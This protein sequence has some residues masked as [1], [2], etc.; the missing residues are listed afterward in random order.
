MYCVNSFLNYIV[1]CIIL[2]LS[3]CGVNSYYL[4]YYFVNVY[5]SICTFF[6]EY[7][8][9][10]NMTEET[11]LAQ[12][13]VRRMK[14]YT[15]RTLAMLLALIMLIGLLPTAALAVDDVPEQAE[16]NAEAI[17]KTDAVEKEKAEANGSLKIKVKIPVG[18]DAPRIEQL[19]R[20]GNYSIT[21]HISAVPEEGD[22]S[23][24]KLIK[25]TVNSFSD[26]DGDGVW[27]GENT[28][29]NLPPMNYRVS[30]SDKEDHSE[31]PGYTSDV[32]FTPADSDPDYGFIEVKSGEPAAE[33]TVEKIYQPAYGKLVITK[34][35]TVPAGFTLSSFIQQ[36]DQFQLKLFYES[37]K[38]PMATVFVENGEFTSKDGELK[39]NA[40]GFVW[41][42]TNV[43]T[44]NY[45][46][47]ESGADPRVYAF[48]SYLPKQLVV[49]PGETTETTLT[50]VYSEPGSRI[51]ITKQLSGIDL[52]D[53]PED[54]GV[55]FTPVD[56]AAVDD[57]VPH[58]LFKNFTKTGDGQYFFVLSGIP[59]GE[60]AVEERNVQISNYT[61]SSSGPV[62]VKVND[63]G[64]ASVLLEN[65]YEPKEGSLEIDKIIK[66]LPEKDFS[67]NT[68]FIIEGPEQFNGG[69]PLAITYA[70]FEKGAYLLESIPVGDYTI[71]EVTA[72]NETG[73]A[74]IEGY[75]LKVTYEGTVTGTES[76]GGFRDAKAESIPNRISIGDKQHG[77]MT[78]TNDYI[79][80][81]NIV[82]TKIFADL[83]DGV[84]PEEFALGLLPPEALPGNP[85]P[86]KY[87][88]EA[89]HVETAADG[90]K[91]S[92]TLPYV[93]YDE[94]TKTFKL[95]GSS[96]E[97]V[98]LE[99]LVNEAGDIYG[100][101]WTLKD[102]PTG[103][104]YLAED[105]GFAPG[106]GW[107][108][109]DVDGAPLQHQPN[110]SLVM[111]EE[112]G[113]QANATKKI[114]VTNHY[115][116][117]YGYISI[118]KDLASDSLTV[119][120]PVGTTFTVRDAEGNIAK[121]AD[122][123]DAVLTYADIQS[124][125]NLLKL[126]AGIKYTIEETKA[127]VEGYAVTATYDLTDPYYIPPVKMAKAKDDTE[128]KQ[129]ADIIIARTSPIWLFTSDNQEWAKENPYVVAFH[130]EYTKDFGTLT[131]KK[132][133]K[134]LPDDLVADG[135][136]TFQCEIT[137]NSSS[138]I[139]T[140]STNEFKK[141]N[142]GD[143]E[144]TVDVDLPYGTYQI[145]EVD[146]DVD[147]YDVAITY[148]DRSVTIGPTYRKDASYSASFTV[149]NT[150]T[151]RTSTINLEKVIAGID[152]EILID[153]DFGFEITGPEGLFGENGSGKMT[154]LY[155]DMED[156]DASSG[157]TGKRL[158]LTVPAGAY[159]IKEIK[160]D[161][162]SYTVHTER[163]MLKWVHAIIGPTDPGEVLKGPAKSDS[164]RMGETAATENADPKLVEF[165]ASK[166]LEDGTD[167]F[168]TNTYTQNPKLTITKELGANSEP[169]AIPAGTTFAIIDEDGNTV[170]T[171][172]YAEF[173]NGSVTVDLPAGTYSVKEDKSSA[174]AGLGNYK[175]DVAY[176]KETEDVG[177]CHMT[178]T[179]ETTSTPGN[180]TTY[181]VGEQIN[182]MI[183]AT[184]D[185]DN[186]I[187]NVLITDALTADEWNIERLDPGVSKAFTTSY[188]VTENDVLAGEVI[189]TAAGKACSSADAET[190]DVSVEPGST[191]DPIGAIKPSADPAP[192]RKPGNTLKASDGTEATNAN[193][194]NEGIVIDVLLNNNATVH[195]TNTYTA[196]EGQK[197][198]VS[199]RK[200]WR[201]AGNQDGI[202]P[203]SIK[204]QLYADGVAF[205]DPV[206]VS[207]DSWQYTWTDLDKTN[208]GKKIEY[209]VKE[210]RVPGYYLEGITGNAQ[211]GYIITN[212]H[213][214]EEA[215]DP[216]E[217]EA[218]VRKVWNDA[219]NR[220][221]KRP[222]SLT[223]TLSNGMTVVL[224]EAN[225]WTATIRHLPKFHYG[226]LINYTWAEDQPEGYKLTSVQTIGT[227]TTLTNSYTPDNPP[228]SPHLPQTGQLLWPILLLA[229]AGILLVVFGCCMRRRAAGKK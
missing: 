69:K 203:K 184:N 91:D 180:G 171:V 17:E 25:L 107:S 185:G 61:L 22:T 166:T 208:A 186:S 118:T 21:F 7:L 4:F 114:T 62:T 8:Y 51:A 227:T 81:G 218:T 130:N 42:L 117:V 191:K 167:V 164:L 128:S 115:E 165:E 113:L 136:Y 110:Q 170:K 147:Y 79:G 132:I 144:A 3:K 2:F 20:D 182:Y 168:F 109:L 192:S 199:V 187:Y 138:N 150:Y 36:I 13:E 78:I 228:Q 1:F 177:T 222:A 46:V 85:Q 111:I 189:N 9:R 27:E 215:E 194:E 149:T 70:D 93:Y 141:N 173:E 211:D 134:G 87:P 86:A 135:A 155:K 74:Y 129:S 75:D 133:V 35:F 219:N 47:E 139:I 31:I 143:Y 188:T 161:V 77:V 195:I 39:T 48:Y 18:S 64:E 174:L 220:Y 210:V 41:T 159:T 127:E 153:Q 96:N 37:D 23:L 98:Q 145:D 11:E 100:F 94:Q 120:I 216:E 151:R 5:F 217:T 52:K 99:E 44:G 156:P 72:Q 106:Y 225:N 15:M 67:N 30:V 84:L 82:I 49:A 28:Y 68:S 92:E 131:V 197:T 26:N 206:T 33:M 175:L 160:E 124:G 63:S 137:Q 57:A 40:D 66:G 45:N 112:I 163:H 123:N 59:A 88:E 229:L 213:I 122:G 34:N 104:Y 204:V 73:T 14:K 205:G 10:T 55:F 146:Y 172:T 157:V 178:I 198:S 214:P 152:P 162:P 108:G 97:N 56:A 148:S 95:G 53:L 105:P 58:A 60:Y 71:T 179:K 223:V 142:D 65:N 103:T 116:P 221:K 200:V 140:L 101:I 193:A 224:N 16:E 89:E 54:A 50:N 176:A 119:D 76:G 125:K 90:R 6:S 121:D 102:F 12:R 43:P 226:K 19:L 181:V 169:V 32:T 183:T 207:E 196:D 158:S 126:P 154:V 212:R 83:K 24:Y 202:R 80:S 38:T 190:P 29:S 209:T 201:D